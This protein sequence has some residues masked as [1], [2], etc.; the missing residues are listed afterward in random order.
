MYLA[1]FVS[2]S[3]MLYGIYI[4]ISRYGI[5]VF[6]LLLLMRRDFK[7]KLSR[8]LKYGLGQRK[9]LIKESGGL[10]HGALFYGFMMLF[11]YTTLI[12]IQ[13]DILPLFTDFR[14]IQGEF[15]ILLEFLGDSFGIAYIIGLLIAVYRRFIAR[16]EKLETRWDDYIIVPMLIWIG[17]SGF[18]LEAFRF[19]ISPSQW[20]IFSPI[21][22]AI[23]NILISIKIPIGIEITFYTIL[24][25]A[26]ML[27]VMFLIAV[28]PYTKLMHVFTSGLNVAIS[29]IKPLGKLNTPF[30]LASMIESGEF[31][32]PRNARSI[33]DFT[34]AQVLAVDAC[35]NC[36]RCQEVCPAY[37]SGR[38]L[39]PRVVIQDLARSL[40]EGGKGDVFRDGIIRESEL[41][42]CTTCNACVSA[43]PVFINQVDYIIEFRR[44][45]V[46]DG[47]VDERKKIFLENIARTNNPF[48]LPQ[49][50]RQNWL[51][52]L[53]VPT[54]NENPNPEYL[55]WVGCQSSYDPRGRKVA[56]AVVKILKAAK[57]NF[58]ILGNEE[59]CTGE[60]VRRMGEE[61]RF[62]ELA[63]RNIEKI[64]RS[65]AKKVI[66][67]CAHCFNTFLNEYPEFGAKFEVIH[68]T[69]LIKQLISENRLKINMS[70][71]SVTFHDPCNLGRI[72]GIFDEPREALQHSGI[73]LKEMER[74]RVSS[75]CC[76]GG[77]ANVWYQVPE[78]K[79][80]GVIRLEEAIQTGANEL[81]V[82][83]PFCITMFEDA[84]K[85]MGLDS[86]SIRDIAEIVADLIVDEG[87]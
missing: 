69:Q 64:S 30:N 12:F 60:P 61:G 20:I 85:T 68:H 79:K 80:I 28:T 23:S 65:G 37:A 8:F 41:W 27:S 74:N 5:S 6:E 66:V 53:G 25:W 17:I 24:W 40:G 77:G 72:N 42:A 22:D 82:A 47:K 49:S 33:S 71:M 51:I 7:K 3:I 19:L 73:E 9:V 35:T 87:K 44:T 18:M 1:F 34:P 83:C 16:L 75:F 58:A 21:G 81:A 10:M 46:S 63:N 36:G 15:Y 31:E 38:D 4:H 76:G 50:E 52:E 55:Y 86:F 13:S 2:G 57:I 45:L 59:F 14:F 11:I 62:Q 78:K 43:C 48:G 26:H 32:L 67:H 54:I 56:A 84:A 39:S 29:S 70:K